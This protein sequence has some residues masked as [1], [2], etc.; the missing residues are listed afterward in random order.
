VPSPQDESPPP[1]K[2]KRLVTDGLPDFSQEEIPDMSVSTST[3]SHVGELAP[4]DEERVEVLVPES[5]P[6]QPENSGQR[7]DRDSSA[8]SE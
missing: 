8:S 3:G 1:K 2:K 7:S 5:D 4:E 6:P